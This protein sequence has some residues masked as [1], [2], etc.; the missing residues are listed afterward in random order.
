MKLVRI[1]PSSRDHNTGG[2]TRSGDQLAD[3]VQTANRL[4]LDDRRFRN[5][6]SCLERLFFEE[7]DIRSLRPER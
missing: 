6:C 7:V 3:D 2:G 1:S 4:N 5:R